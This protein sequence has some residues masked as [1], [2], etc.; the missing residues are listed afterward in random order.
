[1][2]KYNHNNNNILYIKTWQQIRIKMIVNYY[3]PLPYPPHRIIILITI[4][5]CQHQQQWERIVIA[6]VLIRKEKSKI[7][8]KVQHW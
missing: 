4:I 8:E 7:D 2:Y 5:P 3:Y 6:G 1:M